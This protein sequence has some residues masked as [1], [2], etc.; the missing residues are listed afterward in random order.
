VS[1]QISRDTDRVSAEAYKTGRLSSAR[2][3]RLST[4]ASAQATAAERRAAAVGEAAAFEG[5]RATVRTDEQQYRFRRRVE[6]LEDNLQG[7]PLVLI[8]DRIERDG[9][10]L[11]F[12]PAQPTGRR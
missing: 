9:A 6:A 5:L 1:A 11:W 4:L 3:E 2:T 10:E 12:T 8:D 7:R